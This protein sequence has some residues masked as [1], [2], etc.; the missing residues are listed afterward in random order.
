MKT[1]RNISFFMTFFKSK[2]DTAETRLEKF[3]KRIKNFKKPI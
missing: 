1:L 3:F 2:P